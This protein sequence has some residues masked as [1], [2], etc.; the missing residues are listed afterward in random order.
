MHTPRTGLWKGVNLSPLRK[1][2]LLVVLAALAWVSWGGV[3]SA[4]EYLRAEDVAP[5]SLSEA[6]SSFEG[7]T[8][9]LGETMVDGGFIT[10]YIVDAIPALKPVVEDTAFVLAPRSYYFYRDRGDGS[11]SE[12][13]A[14]GGSLSYESGWWMDFLQL[15]IA[16]YTSQKLHGPE[17]R[18]GAGLLAPGQEPYTTLG[19]SYLRVK[20]ADSVLAT[21]YRQSLELPYIN[22]DD[23]R[24]TPAMFQG[25]TLASGLDTE[26]TFFGGHLTHIKPRTNGSWRPMSVEAGA[27]GTDEGVSLV[28]FKYDL[29]DDSYIGAMNQ[30]GWNT[31][32]TL[33]L[34]GQS[35][36]PLGNDLDLSIRAQF[37]DQRD[38]GD[39]LVG[40]FDSQVA[41]LQ[42]SVG[43]NG[44]IG[45][46]SYT[47]TWG[48]TIRSPWGGD[49][50]F[51]SL[52]IS[53][54][55]RTDEES[56]RLGVSWQLDNFGL[57]SWS[58]FV[59]YAWGNTPDGP[60]GSPDQEELNVTLDFRREF[61][62]LENL[63]LRFRVARNDRNQGGDDR[64]DFRIIANHTLHF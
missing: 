20:P 27:P 4:Q 53:D 5:E 45:H 29:L 64:L 52:M 49:P 24:M 14:L 63:W 22:R 7:E 28:G 59:N 60:F 12:T 44:L 1:A 21:L 47:R 42:F 31:F 18:D 3:G 54:F 11:I 38:L 61:G 10:P 43:R 50:S 58:G 9:N 26:L 13:W 48:E 39:A 19:E 57:P 33:Y 2:T 37:T 35:D 55:N 41:G 8:L 15:G 46:V 30:Y 17:D 32:N 36:H 51:N 56:L 62:P 40:D 6:G 23:S 25:V 16:T 34:Q